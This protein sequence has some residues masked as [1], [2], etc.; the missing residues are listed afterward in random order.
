MTGH[1]IK[2]KDQI[3]VK[4]IGFFTLAS[5]DRIHFKKNLLKRI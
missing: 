5:D 2:P 3:F 1:S 4:Y